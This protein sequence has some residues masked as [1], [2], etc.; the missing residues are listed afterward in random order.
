MMKQTLS[1]PNLWF[2]GADK[3][4]LRRATHFTLGVLRSAEVARDTCIPGLGD[5][6]HVDSETIYFRSPVVQAWQNN[7]TKVKDK[8][9]HLSPLP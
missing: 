3:S 8:L 9:Q 1:L 5:K 6:F 7:L 4:Q 2:G